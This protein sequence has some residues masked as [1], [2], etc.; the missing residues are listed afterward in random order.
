MK[1][2]DNLVS[3]CSNNTRKW[4]GKGGP[5]HGLGEF[6]MAHSQLCLCDT[7]RGDVCTSFRMSDARF[8]FS[9]SKDP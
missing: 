2:R 5:S 9:I 4:G 1:T 6:N 3:S 7:Q 8:A